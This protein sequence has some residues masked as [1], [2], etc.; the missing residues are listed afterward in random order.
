MNTELDPSDGLCEI[1]AL[2]EK[3]EGLTKDFAD[4]T[5]GKGPAGNH[6]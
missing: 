4:D 1:V 2:V 3:E 6:P 5:D